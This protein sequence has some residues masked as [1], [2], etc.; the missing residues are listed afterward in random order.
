MKNLSLESLYMKLDKHI[1]LAQ[2][3]TEIKNL[4]FL[5][6]S[7][8]LKPHSYFYKKKE[9]KLVLFDWWFDEFGNSLKIEDKKL[10]IIPNDL[11][12]SNIATT[13]L[14]YGLS[15][16]KIIKISKLVYI[17]HGL[18]DDYNS[19]YTLTFM[20][21]DN[22]L[23]SYYLDEQ[24]KRISPLLLGQEV[25]LTI[26]ENLDLKY[27]LDFNNE[28]NSLPYPTKNQWL[29]CLPANEHLLDILKQDHELIFNL[30]R[31]I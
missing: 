17:T 18:D 5:I 27:F 6:T 3:Y 21:I 26:A 14:Y 10:K 30:I 25:L 29:T 28:I 8:R 2:S 13:D 12:L 4:S 1:L 23:R 31:K 16:D 15:L 11:S 19:F 7:C 20:G 24:W 22:Y 9:S